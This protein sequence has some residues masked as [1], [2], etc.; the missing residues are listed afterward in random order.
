MSSTLYRLTSVDKALHQSAGTDI[1]GGPFFGDQ[2]GMLL[3][4]LSGRVW[5]LF[6]R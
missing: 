5:C 3:E 1:L 6:N 2:V 4:S